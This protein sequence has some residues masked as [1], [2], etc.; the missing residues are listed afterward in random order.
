LF[1]IITTN[2]GFQ[3]TYADDAVYIPIPA[4]ETVDQLEEVDFEL[5]CRTHLHEQ[6]YEVNTT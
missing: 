2:P 5:D 4:T 1:R 3:P 6:K